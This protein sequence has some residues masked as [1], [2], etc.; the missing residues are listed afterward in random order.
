MQRLSD[1]RIQ[2]N[3]QNLNDLDVLKVVDIEANSHSI[4]RKSVGN[5]AKM[6]FPQQDSLFSDS[7]LASC[8]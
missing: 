2:R 8:P 5:M 1:S 7:L 6:A 4:Q 3:L